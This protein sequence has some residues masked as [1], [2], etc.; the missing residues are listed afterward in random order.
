MRFGQ[1]FSEH[2][3][4]LMLFFLPAYAGVMGVLFRRQKRL[5]MEHLIFMFHVH[6]FELLIGLPVL[7]MPTHFMAWNAAV[8]FT[9]APL[10]TFFAMRAVYGGGPWKTAGKVALLTAF[11]FILAGLIGFVMGI[12]AVLR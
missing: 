10:Y 1:W 6:S 12:V 8:S 9:I 11:Y 3:S 2:L 4:T 5:Y 7:L